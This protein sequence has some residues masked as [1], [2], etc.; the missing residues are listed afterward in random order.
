MSFWKILGGVAVGVGAVAAAPFTGGGSLLGAASLA[1]SLAGGTAVAAAVGAGATGAIIGANMG[2]DEEAVNR[3][4][5]EGKAESSVKINKLAEALNAQAA[6]FKSHQDY[7]DYIIALQTVGLACAACDG[8]ISEEERSDIDD[9]IAGVSST[10]LP[11]SIIKRIYE[12]SLTHPT[13]DTAFELAQPFMETPE[14]REIFENL[15]ELTMAA[16]EHIDSKEEAF[17]KTWKQ[18]AA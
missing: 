15:I 8:H 6:H 3:G 1:G 9:F 17:F 18:M 10:K 2:G 7:F 12:V 4:R 16:D 5:R 14:Q 11:E 13:I